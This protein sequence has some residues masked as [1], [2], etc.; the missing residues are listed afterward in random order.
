MLGVT[1]SVLIYLSFPYPSNVKIARPN[2]ECPIK[3]NF[4]LGMIV[5][6]SNPSDLG[7]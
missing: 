3:L 7:G 2:T 4:K 5:C 1:C 6:S